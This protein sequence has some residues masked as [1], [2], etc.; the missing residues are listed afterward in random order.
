MADDASTTTSQDGAAND[1][2]DNNVD[3]GNGL[4][5]AEQQAEVNKIVAQRLQRQK[6]QFKGHDEYKQAAERLAEI[7]KAGQTELELVTGERDELKSGLSQLGSENLRLRV[8]LEKSIPADLIDRL[9]GETKEEL[10]ADADKLLEMV[11][12]APSSFDG[13]ARRSAPAGADMNRL[14]RAAAGRE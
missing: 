13:G 6:E 12:P 1:A 8:A 5:T 4:F 14:L 2:E 9:R 11:A 10:E 3:G 7:E